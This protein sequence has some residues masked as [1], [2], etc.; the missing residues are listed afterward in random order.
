MKYAI[1]GAKMQKVDQ[2]FIK[3]IGIPSLVL[4]ER[5]ALGVTRRLFEHY[6]LERCLI[7]VGSGNNG[8]DGL[9]IARQLMEQG[10]V[11]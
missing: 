10:I 7:V 1:S 11:P 4:M 9:A 2:Q 5:A 8:A 3:H 6:C